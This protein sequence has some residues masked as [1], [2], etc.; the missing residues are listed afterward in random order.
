MGIIAVIQAMRAL[1]Q[2]AKENCK[3]SD[4]VVGQILCYVADEVLGRCLESVA[5]FFN[6]YVFAYIATCG[7]DFKEASDKVWALVTDSYAEAVMNYSISDMVSTLG[8]IAG[9]V[10]DA[11][12]SA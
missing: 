10:M 2:I 5:Q 1:V 6:A 4:N 3:D 8:T 9:G 12:A 7:C 11:G